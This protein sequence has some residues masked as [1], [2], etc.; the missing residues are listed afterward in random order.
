MNEKSAHVLELPKILEQLAR[1]AT[2]SAGEEL[3]RQL[4]PTTDIRQAQA[5]QQETTEARKLFDVKTEL[6]LGGVRDV[7]GPAVQATRGMV[8]EPQVLLD[9]RGTLRR[10]TSI[11]RTFSRLHDQYPALT[12]IA[13]GLE[14]CT[15][16]Q[17][18]I[19]QVLDDNGNVLDSASPKLAMVRR[20]MRLAFDR[21]QSRLNSLVNN[22]NNARFL[23]EVLITQRHGRYVIPL[24]AEFKGRIPGIVHDSS[25]S[26][27]T[28]FIEPLATVE[29]NNSWRE[30]QLEEENEIRRIL[31]ALSD[32]VG[33]EAEF[34]VRTVDGLAHLDMIFAKARYANAIRATAPLRC[35]VISI[36]VK[37]ARTPDRLSSWKRRDIRCCLLEPLSRLIWRW[38]TTPM[39]WSSLDRTRAARPSRSKRLAC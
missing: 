15:G 29:L 37:A 12:D 4:T 34:I 11:R 5:W 25:S 10:A 30:L 21:L 28:V 16:L 36:H 33:H 27:A 38:M 26:G 6:S 39:H 20:D 13:D 22:P 8:L 9:I 31:Q 18:E 3:I 24:R 19:S 23:Q 1:H 17:G 14:E 7:R 2:F 35:C 32:L